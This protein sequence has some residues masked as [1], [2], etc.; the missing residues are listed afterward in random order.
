ML[1]I[2]HLGTHTNVAKV[3]TINSTLSGQCFTKSFVTQQTGVLITCF[4]SMGIK[5]NSI[6]GHILPDY[7]D[8]FLEQL[9]LIQDI[10]DL[11]S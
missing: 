10:G 3:K 9:F 11:Q 4:R 7:S 1:T 2:S 5:D 6:K 8:N